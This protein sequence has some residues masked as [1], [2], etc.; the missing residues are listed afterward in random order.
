MQKNV[1]AN[2]QRK[3]PTANKVYNGKKDIVKINA[4]KIIN[5]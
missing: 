1:L 5:V 4:G 3:C 2:L